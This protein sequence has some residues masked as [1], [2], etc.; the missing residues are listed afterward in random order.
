MSI[1]YKSFSYNGEGGKQTKDY[2]NKYWWK[3]PKSDLPQDVGGVINFLQQNQGSRITQQLISARLYGNLAIMGINGLTYS[4]MASV[5]SSLRD[6]ISY[7]VVQSCIDTVASKMA[8]NKPKPMF[9]TSGGD[10]KMQRKAKKLNDFVDGIFYE[11]KAYDI[12][13]RIFVDACVFG[14]GVVKVFSEHG[15]VKF[16]RV[17]S[18]ELYVDEVEGFYGKP[19]SLH[20]VKTVDRQVLLDAFPGNSKAI[21][22]ANSAKVDNA[23]YQPSVSDGVLVRESWHLPSGPDATD[24]LH[25]ITIDNAVLL[26]ES[27]DKQHFPFAFFKWTPRLHG[28]WG[29]GLA[30]QIQNIQLE[31]NKLLW[32]IQ[33]SMHL[34][35]SFKV[36]LENGSKLV[37][38]HFNNDIGA[39]I[40]YSG[41]KPEYIVP[42]IVA[43]EVYAHLQ[44]LKNAAFEQA[45]VSQL[46]AAS[47]KPEGL[48]SGK[49]L[50]E[51]ND[52]ESER[53]LMVGRCWE[54]FFLDLAHLAIDEAKHI[55]EEEGSYEVKVPGKKFIQSIDW[56]DVDLKE[57]EYIMKMFPVSSLPQD[58]AGRLQTIQEY[59][60]AG[61][62][63][64]RT[65]R[66]LLDFPDL[67]AT[68]DLFNATED[69]L[70]EI[71]EEMTED[72]E[73][74]PPEP[75]DDL[76]LARELAL[77]YYARGK[78][79][80]LEEERLELLRQFI[81][82]I[83]VLEG[84]V[85]QSMP[86]GATNAAGAVPG[87]PGSP[88]ASPEAPAQSDLIPNIPQ[89]VQ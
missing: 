82:Q 37:K 47:K 16:E 26:S 49:A 86:S 81:S 29:Q 61:Y 60:Q 69:Y 36:L 44:T 1:D 28:F 68:E 83:D 88:Q 53:F 18:A 67:A 17:L 54:Q 51:F 35:G 76:K 85:M 34:A 77:E 14:D 62:I 56:A 66:R 8:K 27:Y 42:P 58:P 3:S 45:G 72:G 11:N 5:Q 74:T 48:D 39:L 43:P 6:R 2:F 10:Y 21:K 73:Y 33:R 64:P 22:E 24:G 32:V 13:Q 57:D 63:T 80:G 31:I 59:A 25:A 30:E 89:G 19:R 41:Q 79:S 71:L 38:E 9:L 65:A 78:C 40:M 75:F 50:R 7:N 15:R 84:S 52:I 20:Q 23:A 4:K 46:S 87:G 55:Y 12:G 70:H